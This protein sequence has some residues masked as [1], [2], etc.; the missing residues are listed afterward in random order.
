MFVVGHGTI[1][2]VS[3]GALIAAAQTREGFVET[4]KK[5]LSLV[6]AQGDAIHG[7]NEFPTD[8][9]G[10]AH[11]FTDVFLGVGDERQNGR[12]QDTAEDPRVSKCPQGVEAF[13][14][15]A[16]VRFQNAG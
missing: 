1:I 10:S 11:D 15:G 16:D 14:A 8:F 6:G 2:V 12:Q 3:I 7:K 9:G 13:G 5:V 4:I